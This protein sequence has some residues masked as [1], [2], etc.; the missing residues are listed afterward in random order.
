[1]LKRCLVRVHGGAAPSGNGWGAFPLLLVLLCAAPALAHH[2]LGIPHYSYDERYPQTPVLT[3][4]VDAGAYEVKMTG[5]PGMPKPG[6]RCFLHVYI[7]GLESGAPFDD[8]VRLTVTRDRL[9]GAD[10]VVYGPIE[11][12]LEEA[13]YKFHPEFT[14][15]ANYVARI[16]FEAD[17][18]PWVIDLPIVVGEPGNPWA[19]LGGVGVAAILFLLVVRAIRIKMRRRAVMPAVAA[20]SAIHP[21]PSR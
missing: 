2:I 14:L 13:V 16:E 19:V 15:E 6:D 7:R 5:Y 9:I 12:R 8:R 4:R 11:S 10:P 21:G 18:A 3:Y 1:M 17:G 20:A